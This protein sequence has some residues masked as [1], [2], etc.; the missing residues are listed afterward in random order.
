M[1]QRAGRIAIVAAIVAVQFSAGGRLPAQT[2]DDPILGKWVL[3]R[4]RS[5]FSG[6]PPEKRTAIFELIAEGRLRHMTETLTAN[7][8]VD[9]VEY[10]AKYDGRDNPI[11]NSFLW[12]VAV[13]QV[14]ARTTERTG[15]VNGQV[16]ETSIRTV[17]ADGRT[18]TITMNGGS[19][20]NEYSSVQVFTRDV[21]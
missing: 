2:K 19:E 3:D 16:V 17:S 18:L 9:R 7:G 10:T 14:D 15:K 1:S 20:G 12:S 8:S 5:E 6:A 13:K 11:S 21:P 4:A